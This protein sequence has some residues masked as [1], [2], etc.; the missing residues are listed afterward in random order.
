MNRFV[1]YL[2]YESFF[3][4][5]SLYD[6][7]TANKVSLVNIKW[8]Q[9]HDLDHFHWPLD[10]DTYGSFFNHRIKKHDF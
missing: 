2:C 8:D 7:Y 4:K 9:R 3:M 5:A 6:R 10:V 1:Y